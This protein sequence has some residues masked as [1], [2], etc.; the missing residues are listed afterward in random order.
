LDVATDDL[1][2]LVARLIDPAQATETVYWGRN[3][4]YATTLQTT[5]DPELEVV[6]KQFRN[7]GLGR[8]LE[9]RLRGSKAERSWRI[10]CA[11]REAGLPTPQPIALIE[12][13]APEGPSLYVSERITG[14][15]EV[16]HFFRRLSGDPSAEAFPEVEPGELLEALGKLARQLHE[17]GIWYRDLSIG[18][19][20]VRRRLD[21][22]EM[23]LVDPNR[24]RLGRRLGVWRRSRDICRFPIVD[25]AHRHAFLRGYWGLV[26]KHASPRWWLYTASVRAYLLKHAVK[27]R[28]RRGGRRRV[29]RVGTHHAHI[30]DPSEDASRRDKVVWD[31]LSDQPHQHARGLEKTIIRIADAG[32]HV[33]ELAT[34]ARHLPAALRRYRQLAT[35]LYSTPAAIGGF[36]VCLRPWPEGPGAQLAALD[37]LGVRSVLLRLHPWEESHDAELTLAHELTQ[38]GFD[39]TFALPQTRELVRDPYA[40]ENAIAHIAERFVPYGSRFEIG[41]AINRSK[42]GIWKRSEYVELYRRAA[43]RLRA[44]G[45]AIQLLGPAVIDFEHHVTLALAN[46]REPELKLDIVT[47]LLY[48]DRRGAPENQQ[49]GFDTVGKAVLLRAIADTGRN[50]SP[51]CWITEV[52]WPLWEGPHS[53]AGREVSV[54]EATHADYLVRYYILVLAT[55][56]IERV[57]WWQLIARGYGLCAPEPDGQL[58]WRPAHQALATLVRMLDGATCTGPASTGETVRLYAFERSEDRLMVAWTTGQPQPLDL[59]Q[60]ARE[61]YDRDGQP[62][63]VGDGVRFQLTGSPQYFV[64]PAD[65]SSSA[66]DQRGRGL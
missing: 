10:A 44:A 52:N 60:Q 38:R 33:R 13:D 8:R 30:P 49:L 53:P 63:P 22:L 25:A 43:K 17:H 37:A 19:V 21:T 2:S 24:A 40:W 48:V 58:R 15:T 64:V 56:L 4:L 9:R 61:R 59:P 66:D 7:Q 51:R 39:L 31:R 3:Y 14:Y 62:Q 32:D 11:V 16:R 6:V 26:P 50:S 35:E 47:S 12:S 27:S 34:V 55:G 54:D 65:P 42:W 5:A 45:D 41:H 23:M 57:Y 36:G 20:L 18:N 28:L 46:R 1:E 29:A